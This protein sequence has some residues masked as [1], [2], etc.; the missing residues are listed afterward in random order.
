MAKFGIDIPRS[1]LEQHNELSQQ[2]HMVKRICD[3]A[4]CLGLLK[5]GEALPQDVDIVRFDGI[6]A[7]NF[8]VTFPEKSS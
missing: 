4:I 7:V 6:H 8:E 1:E 3:T 2:D 5:R